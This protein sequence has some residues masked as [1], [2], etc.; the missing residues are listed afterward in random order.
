M[1]PLATLE[2]F[3]AWFGAFTPQPLFGREAGR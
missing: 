1:A 2:G 3:V